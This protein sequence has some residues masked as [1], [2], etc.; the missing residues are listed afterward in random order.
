MVGRKRAIYLSIK[1]TRLGDTDQRG[2]WL[3]GAATDQTSKATHGCLVKA[4]VRLYN[5]NPN[6]VVLSPLTTHAAATVVSFRDSLLLTTVK[7]TFRSEPLTALFSSADTQATTCC[8]VTARSHP[9]P[10]KLWST[11]TDNV[12]SIGECTEESQE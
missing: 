4:T 12:H 5:L 8:G 1:S 7:Q 2:V 10:T 9:F 6:I 11:S 3:V